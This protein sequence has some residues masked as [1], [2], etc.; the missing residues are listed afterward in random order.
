MAQPCT[1]S[2]WFLAVCMLMVISLSSHFTINEGYRPGA[3][4]GFGTATS[5]GSESNSGEIDSNN[6][7]DNGLDGHHGVR[8]GS[9]RSR[10][11]EENGKTKLVREGKKKMLLYTP[12][13]QAECFLF[14]KW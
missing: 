7:F 3:F 5:W 10:C 6:G 4:D 11:T 8:S 14:K 2:V 12:A 1:T 13:T 9:K